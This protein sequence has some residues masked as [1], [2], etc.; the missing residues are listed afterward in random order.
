MNE[1]HLHVIEPVPSKHAEN[2]ERIRNEIEHPGLS[3]IV[4]ARPCIHVKR[5]LRRAQRQPA[6]V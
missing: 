5:K 1:E 2:V 6:A 4:A 3:V